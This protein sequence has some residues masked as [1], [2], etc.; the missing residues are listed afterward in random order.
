MVIPR[1]KIQNSAFKLISHQTVQQN[2]MAN[3]FKQGQN[4]LL[5]LFTKANAYSEFSYSSLVIKPS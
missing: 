5:P 4:A 3:Q 1:D 2:P